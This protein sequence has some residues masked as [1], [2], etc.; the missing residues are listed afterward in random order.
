MAEMGIGAEIKI[1]IVGCAGRMGQTLARLAHESEGFALAGGS[2]AAGHAAVGRDLG[3]VAGLGPLGLAVGGDPAAL[4]QNAEAVLDFTAPEA[5]VAHAE[6]AAETGTRADH[7]YHRARFRP[8]QARRR[9][10]ETGR[11]RPRPQHESLRHPDDRA[12]ATGRG[13]PR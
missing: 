11:H 13:E 6:V 9:G 12:R 4:F 5:S 10:R 3:E 8:R 2:E 1:G 7:R